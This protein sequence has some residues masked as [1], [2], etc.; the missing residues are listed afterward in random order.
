M[1][2]PPPPVQPPLLILTCMRSFSSLVSTMLGQHPGLYGLPEVNPFLAPTLGATVDVLS[3]VRKRTLDGIFR[4]VAEVEAG[5]QDERAVR[6]AMAWVRGRRG[7]S[8]VE[9]MDHL[10]ARVAPRRLVEK[11]PSTALAPDRVEAATRLFP[12][13]PILH[14]HRHPVATTASIAKIT[15]HENGRGRGR[16]PEEAWLGANR[17][18]LEAGARLPPGRF[19]ALRG[20]DALE[21]PDGFLAQVCEWLDLPCGEAELAAMKRPE[22]SPFAR[23][24]PPSAPF[25]NDPSFLRHPAYERRPIPLPPLDAPL[26]WAGGRRLRPETVALGEVLG[27]GE[28][29]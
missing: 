12:G 20:E 2:P 3:V 26:P 16:D 15:G 9:F 28:A 24:G 11:S 1:T 17:A 7:W 14:L 23:L 22:L 18:I 5:A 27:Y 8:M 10:A 4:A 25:G 21:D 6:A 29:A 19:M 13:A